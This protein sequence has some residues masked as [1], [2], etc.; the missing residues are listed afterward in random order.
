MQFFCHA[1]LGHGLIERREIPLG[2]CRGTIAEG[3][4]DTLSVDAVAHRQCH[5]VL[6]DGTDLVPFQVARRRPRTGLAEQGLA[7]MSI[8]PCGQTID[9]TTC[10]IHII[11]IK[12]INV[13]LSY[14]DG[15]LYPNSAKF[16]QD[17]LF[18][19]KTHAL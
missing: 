14:T 13:L 8:S 19:S 15:H 2:P 1:V 18:Y 12:R 7:K 3:L 17:G 6:R 16:R 11:W 9:S 5:A 4:R 10:Y